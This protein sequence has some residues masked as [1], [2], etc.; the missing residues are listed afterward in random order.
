VRVLVIE[1]DFSGEKDKSVCLW[2]S[3]ITLSYLSTVCHRTD[4]SCVA[5]K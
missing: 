5:V 1:T 2:P 4:G 3:Q